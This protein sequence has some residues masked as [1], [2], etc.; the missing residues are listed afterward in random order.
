VQQILK[1]VLCLAIRLPLLVAQPI[2]PLHDGSELFLSLVGRKED[3]NRAGQLT[4]V[5]VPQL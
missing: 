4:G 2:N 1:K 5:A 3:S